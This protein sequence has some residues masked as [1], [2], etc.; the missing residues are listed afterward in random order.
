MGVPELAM[1][2]ILL[3]ERCYKYF[4]THVKTS[5]CMNGCCELHTHSNNSVK[6]EKHIEDE[7][8]EDAQP[9]T[10]TLTAFKYTVSEHI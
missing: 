10:P 1:I 6:R 9:A 8:Q 4:F 3:F 7:I 5:K 2:S